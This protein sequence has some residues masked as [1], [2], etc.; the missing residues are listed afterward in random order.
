MKKVLKMVGMFL[1]A[2]TLFE[3]GLGIYEYLMG[4]DLSQTI[5]SWKT[6]LG[7]LA[8]LIG[9]YYYGWIMSYLVNK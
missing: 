3:I 4:H 7:K 2:I 9:A 1:L 6:F 5:P 8:V